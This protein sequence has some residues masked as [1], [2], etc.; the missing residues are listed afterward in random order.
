MGFVASNEE[1]DFS[2]PSA[3]GGGHAILEFAD[4]KDSNRYHSEILSDGHF[5]FH[6]PAGEYQFFVIRLRNQS[7]N[8]PVSFQVGGTSPTYIG[9]LRIKITNDRWIRGHLPAIIAVEDDYETYETALQTL[10]TK[11]DLG[12][13]QPKKSLMTLSHAKS[14]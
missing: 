3:L 11:F 10:G 4:V 8:L 12:P 5:Y 9:N 2:M 14:P 13:C 7:I 1:L 6:L